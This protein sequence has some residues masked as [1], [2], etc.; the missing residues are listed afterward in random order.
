[1]DKDFIASIFCET[2][3]LGLFH[4]NSKQSIATIFSTWIVY[5][6]RQIIR[7]FGQPDKFIQVKNTE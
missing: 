4:P 2:L 3:F 6:R 7:L 5:L 1:M